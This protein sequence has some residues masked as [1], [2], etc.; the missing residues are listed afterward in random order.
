MIPSQAVG[1]NSISTS[2]SDASFFATSISKPTSSPFLS[3]IAH[4]TNVDMPTFSAPRFLIVSMTLSD[5]SCCWALCAAAPVATA[6][7][8]TAAIPS[9]SPASVNLIAFSL[10]SLS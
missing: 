8:S 1:M 6:M 7:P 3:R 9:F 5:E 4:G 2:M 10:D